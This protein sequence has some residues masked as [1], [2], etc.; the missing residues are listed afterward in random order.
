MSKKV[1]ISQIN[2]Y[3][4]IYF[5]NYNYKIL[6]LFKIYKCLIKKYIDI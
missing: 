4:N 6:K 3:I 1:F 5:L 2:L